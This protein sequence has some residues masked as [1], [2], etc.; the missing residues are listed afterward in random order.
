MKVL[1]TF[2]KKKKKQFKYFKNESLEDVLEKKKNN[3]KL[4]TIL[5]AFF[6]ELV[7][8]LNGQFDNTGP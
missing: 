7:K 5:P 1:K 6:Q 8:L 4:V 3:L 2:L